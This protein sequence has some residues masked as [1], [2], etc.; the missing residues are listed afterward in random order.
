MVPVTPRFVNKIL[1]LILYGIIK[2]V[3]LTNKV[4][5]SN[6]VTIKTVLPKV[7]FFLVSIQSWTMSL[8]NVQTKIEPK[9]VFI[10][11][12][13]GQI[14][15]CT[16]RK[17]ISWHLVTLF[18]SLSFHSCWCKSNLTAIHKIFVISRQRMPCSNDVSNDVSFVVPKHHRW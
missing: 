7:Y 9:A 10:R 5:S 12:K 2:I 4:I 3:N 16:C 13:S 8:F 17:C 11:D 1:W 6:K 18:N 14:F 15:N